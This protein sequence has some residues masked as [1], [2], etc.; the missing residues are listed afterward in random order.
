M[1]FCCSNLQQLRYFLELAYNGKN[2]F[3][4]QIQPNQISVQ[5]VIEDR[6][7]KILRKKIS[8]VGAG[9]TDAGVHAKKMYIH[10]DY[11][12]ID[13][14][15]WNENQVME[16]INKPLQIFT[17]NT[18][19]EDSGQEGVAQNANKKSVTL[20]LKEDKAK[21]IF[22]KLVATSDV[23]VENFR[24]GVMERSFISVPNTT[25]DCFG[26]FS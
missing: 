13:A 2:Y 25:K 22:R 7:S 9:R 14:N 20:N 26:L 6:L 23:I 8:I 10:F 21:E 11:E 1:Y 4:Y 19:L 24:P 16:D 5:E 12:D 15:N 17:I 18:I 3:G